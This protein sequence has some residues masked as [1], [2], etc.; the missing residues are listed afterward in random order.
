MELTQLSKLS[1]SLAS[2]G[3]TAWSGNWNAKDQFLSVDTELYL[4]NGEQII[5]PNMGIINSNTI[6]GQ[7]QGFKKS[8][9][10]IKGLS[11]LPEMQTARAIEKLQ[12][13]LQKLAVI[14]SNFM[15]A[16]EGYP[17]KYDDST[18][19]YQNGFIYIPQNDGTYDKIEC[20]YVVIVKEQLDT[21]GKP[22]VNIS[23]KIEQR[24]G[25]TQ[26]PDAPE[27]NDKAKSLLMRMLG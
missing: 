27:M 13:N 7:V 24:K 1:E 8:S 23:F 18:L 25:N 26:L 11:K 6:N 15:E 19:Y 20:Q 3:Y 14:A 16:V 5:Y 4:D 10:Q 12:S 17:S 2:K 22:F 9:E 21:D